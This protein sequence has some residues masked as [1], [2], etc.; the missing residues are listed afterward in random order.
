MPRFAM[1]VCFAHRR[2]VHGDHGLSNTMSSE[3]SLCTVHLMH[4][5][6]CLHMSQAM[7]VAN[8]PLLRVVGCAL[9]GLLRVLYGPFG[10]VFPLRC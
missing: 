8:G 10:E 5:M 2:L 6:R 3:S 1:K 7:Y 4:I 9:H